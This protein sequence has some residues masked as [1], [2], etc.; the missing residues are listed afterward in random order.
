MELNWMQPGLI[1]IALVTLATL[2][3]APVALVG[4]WAVLRTRRYHR[5]SLLEAEV[6]QTLAQ[7]LARSSERRGEDARPNRALRQIS[8]AGGRK[9]FS[10]HEFAVKSAAAPFEYTIRR[11]FGSVRQRV[12]NLGGFAKAPVLLH[13]RLGNCV[14]V[15]RKLC[16]N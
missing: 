10:Q 11:Q 15:H 13:D 16:L 9:R 4:R 2:M 3:L 1:E 12:P 6:R 5:K 7:H 8:S 14:M